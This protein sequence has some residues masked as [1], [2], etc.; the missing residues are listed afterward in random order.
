MVQR[1]TDNDPRIDPDQAQRRWTYVS[2]QMR[3]Y[4][5]VSP[6]ERE[7][8]QM[9]VTRDRAEWRGAQTTGSQYHI[10]EQVLGELDREGFTQ[11]NLEQRGFTIVT[12]ID[13]RAQR[14]AED[15]VNKIMR[16][17]PENLHPAMV[18]T[19]PKTGAVR[20][21]YGGGNKAGGF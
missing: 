4:H 19:D 9:P 1:P 13:P 8:M 21:Y 16:D 7:T 12:N 17:Q 15:A 20:A 11:Q 6:E 10:R 5:F 14:A 18:A 2:D 3:N